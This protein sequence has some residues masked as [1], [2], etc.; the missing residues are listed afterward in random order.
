MCKCIRHG[1]KKLFYQHRVLFIIYIFIYVLLIKIKN[2][3]EDIYR[4]CRH[5]DIKTLIPRIVGT[6]RFKNIKRSQFCKKYG[7][8]HNDIII[9]I[10]NNST[11]K[12]RV[13]ADECCIVTI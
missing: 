4:R 1:T 2:Y 6:R 12:V 3:V 5:G 11:Y 10:I 9:L 13:C 8:A 7:S